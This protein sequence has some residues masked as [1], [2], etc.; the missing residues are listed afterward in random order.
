MVTVAAVVLVLLPLPAIAAVCF[1]ASPLLDV[2]VM[3]VAGQGGSFFSLA[4][5]VVGWCGTGTSMP[6]SGAAHIR[7]DGKA[8]FGISI[9]GPVGSPATC[10]PGWYQGTLNAPA[11][12]TGTGFHRNALGGTTALTFVAV[13]CPTIPQAVEGLTGP[14]GG[15]VLP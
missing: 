14:G 9:H 3:D 10:V 11:F 12:N 1:N 4:G 8:H 2:V 6:L 7:P 13:T 15:T 5:E